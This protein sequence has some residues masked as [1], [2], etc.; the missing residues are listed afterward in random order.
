MRFTANQN[1]PCPDGTDMAAVALY[2]QCLAEQ[3]EA[4]LV[5][6]SAA[7]SS[8]LDAP[9]AIWSNSVNQN[10]VDGTFLIFDNVTS[11]NWPTVPVGSSPSLP[12]LRGWYYIGANANIVDTPPVADQ[13]RSLI[14]S[15]NQNT[16]VVS[17]DGVLAQFQDTI[18]DSF[19]TAGENVLPAGTVF[20]AG[21]DFTAPNP[22][23]LTLQYRSGIGGVVNPVDTSQTPAV[24]LWV[25]Y[26]GDTPQIGVA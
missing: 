18:L 12:N 7:F 5:A 21:G 6:D 9:V 23:D 1:L 3:V 22:V 8:F 11:N 14:L 2:M 17:G 19:T 15:A 20:F 13:D 25:I 26:L 4:E 24:R 16:G 10:L